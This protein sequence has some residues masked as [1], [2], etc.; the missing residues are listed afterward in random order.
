L[1]TPTR[2]GVAKFDSNGKL[3]DVVEKPKKP[4]SNYAITGVYFF[5]PVVFDMIKQLKP[6]WE[7]EYE[8]TDTIRLMIQNGYR[9]GCGI[10][11]GWWFDTGKKDDILFVNS[12]ILDE[13]INLM[14]AEK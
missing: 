11:E 9:V 4:P 8:I 5:K 12:V 6:S 2:F 7:G 3:V 1:R 10:H 13:R 14:F